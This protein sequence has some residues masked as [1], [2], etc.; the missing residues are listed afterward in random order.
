LFVQRDVSVGGMSEWYNGDC[1]LDLC[2][3]RDL[4]EWEL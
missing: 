2:W 1:V 3:R 4:L